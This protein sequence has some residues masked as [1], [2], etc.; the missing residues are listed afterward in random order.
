M[1]ARGVVFFFWGGGLQ[2]SDFVS[3][4]SQFSCLIADWLPLFPPV[5]RDSMERYVFYRLLYSYIHTATSC[6]AR[7]F[8]ESTTQTATCFSC[9]AGDSVCFAN[10]H[11]CT[12]LGQIWEDEAKSIF[13]RRRGSNSLARYIGLIND[14]FWFSRLHAIYVWRGRDIAM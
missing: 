1:G 9:T 12:C 2:F 13:F 3:F 4:A 6:A 14:M 7:K 5:S 11:E 10:Q 8:Q